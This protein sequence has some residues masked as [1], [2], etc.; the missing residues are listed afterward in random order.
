MAHDFELHRITDKLKAL[1]QEQRRVNQ[2]ILQSRRDE[3]FELDHTR[4][5]FNAQIHALEEK[6]QHI[7]KDMERRERE[8]LALQKR[9][10]DELE[11]EQEEQFGHKTK[12]SH[13]RKF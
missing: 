11:E 3:Q 5:R 13:F 9:I 7:A 4:R 8:L 2:K 10:R 12:R 6:Q 1:T